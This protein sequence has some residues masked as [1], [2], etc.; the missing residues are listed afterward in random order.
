[1]SKSCNNMHTFRF[2]KPLVD[3]LT[4]LILQFVDMTRYISTAKTKDMKRSI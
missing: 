4:T 2:I 1:M 3:K